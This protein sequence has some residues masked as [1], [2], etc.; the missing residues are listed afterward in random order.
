M[1]ATGA[2][3]TV[4]EPLVIASMKTPVGNIVE[5]VCEDGRFHTRVFARDPD[6]NHEITP[7]EAAEWLDLVRKLG[8]TVHATL[9]QA[10]A[11]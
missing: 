4:A 9:P 1:P 6:L 2:R 8:G 7:A 11:S 5:L 3:A 10:A